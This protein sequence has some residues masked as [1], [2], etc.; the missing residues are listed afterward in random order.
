VNVIQE[1]SSA[2]DKDG[3]LF[4]NEVGEWAAEGIIVKATK[5][6]DGTVDYSVQ[7]D[8]SPVFQEARTTHVT[9]TPWFVWV[10]N[11]ETVWHFDG[12][13][14]RLLAH[15]S[16][17]VSHRSVGVADERVTMRRT[18][19]PSVMQRLPGELQEKIRE[20][21]ASLKKANESLV[22]A[23]LVEDA[24]GV[25]RALTDGADANS[26]FKGRVNPMTCLEQ[27]AKVGNLR[28]IRMLLD[29]GADPNQRVAEYTPLHSASAYGQIE[30]I[31]LLLEHGADPGVKPPVNLRWAN[32]RSVLDIA[33]LNRQKEATQF[34]VE[35]GIEV[36]Q[37]TTEIAQSG[38]KYDQ[39]HKTTAGKEI[40]DWLEAKAMAKPKRSR[41]PDQDEGTHKRNSPKSGDE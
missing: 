27:A 8:F 40:L 4:V 24:Y 19:P 29:H 35:H 9:K 39:T 17:K 16:G 22:H 3:I 31:K 6:V 18:P 32:D 41:S 13:R 30:S 5:G 20:G 11:K 1:T 14:L 10:E 2:T 38:A 21:M 34:W 26:S 37:L 25:E 12:L 36:S 28:I 23:V 33:V 15:D 7:G